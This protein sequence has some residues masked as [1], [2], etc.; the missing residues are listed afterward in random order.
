M[1]REDEFCPA[2][3]YVFD[4]HFCSY[5]KGW[6]QFDSRQDASYYGHWINPEKRQI[7][8]YCE[9]D[10][11]KFTFD[12]DDEMIEWVQEFKDNENLGFIGIDPGFG[13]VLKSTLIAHGL[14]PFLHKS[15]Q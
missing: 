2:D 5:D 4:M 8:S 13:E 14:G 12:N 3:R 1:K 7:V 11:S 6:A 15:S 10:V 9:G